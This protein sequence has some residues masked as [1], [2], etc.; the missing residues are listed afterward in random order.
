MR[1]DSLEVADV[2]SALAAAFAVMALAGCSTSET[3]ETNELG[4]AHSTTSVASTSSVD[5]VASDV[6]L[7][8]AGRAAEAGTAVPLA[9]LGADKFAHCQRSARLSAICPVLVPRVGARYLSHLSDDDGGALFTLERGVPGKAPPH[10]AHVTIGASDIERTDPFDHPTLTDPPL[11]LADD[12]LDQ[13]RQRP[14][15]F[16]RV[17][18]A[19]RE[20]VLFLAPPFPNGGMLGDHLVFAWG[21]GN[22]RFAY[23]LHAWKP[24][25]DTAAT[26]REMLEAV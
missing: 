3:S 25:A 24:L 13:E 5:D 8:A 23:S 17:T 7:S 14:V 16:G 21:R 9:Q 26:L 4:D 12:L 18:W 15:S 6:E 20:G 1:H 2:R 10:G 19:G 11:P 22:A